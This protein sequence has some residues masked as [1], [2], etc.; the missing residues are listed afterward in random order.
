MNLLL[1]MASMAVMILLPFTLYIEGNVAAVTW[2]SLT[3]QVLGNAT[4]AM[5]A[6]TWSS[7]T[8][9]V[10]GNTT[11]T[12]VFESNPRWCWGTEMHHLLRHR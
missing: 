4:A 3:L 2:S 8:L 7:L 12:M 11:A 1:Y 6:V 5:A 9:Q 10:L